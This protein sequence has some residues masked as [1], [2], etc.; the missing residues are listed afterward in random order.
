MDTVHAR[1]EDDRSRAS[2]GSVPEEILC[3]I[4]GHV[5]TMWWGV[6]ARVSWTWY[7]CCE[8]VSA[9]ARR[10][11]GAT[12]CVP[13]LPRIGEAHMIEAASNGNAA[14]AWWL[15]HGVGV[16]W[17][18]DAIEAAALGGHID[19]VNKMQMLHYVE[20]DGRCIV[21]AL[22]GGGMAFAQTLRSRRLWPP[23]AM[24]AAIALERPDWVRTLV[25]DR[26]GN[27]DALT[28]TRLALAIG[29]DD[30]A[31]MVADPTDD[32]ECARRIHGM[33]SDPIVRAA[34]LPG[35][36]GRDLALVVLKSMPR[37]H[38]VW[39]WLRDMP[40]LRFD[41]WTFTQAE[42]FWGVSRPLEMECCPLVKYGEAAERSIMRSAE[43]GKRSKSASP[44]L[45]SLAQSNGA[46]DNAHVIR[47]ERRARDSQRRSQRREPA[48]KTR[49]FRGHRA[50]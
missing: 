29:R 30:M 49:M 48:V 38:V 3:A 28:C 46:P 27:Y 5:P 40:D 42:P 45:A 22:I 11:A 21:A 23:Q 12:P 16:R 25:G 39:E 43:V 37:G 20:P 4:L 36:Q 24:V 7:R 17:A 35:L 2:I 34:Y 26:C 9:A 6:A 32:L 31:R 44:T 1:G 50:W 13:V 14:T 33:Y 47:T 19:L 10:R 41:N 8:T 15:A 18:R